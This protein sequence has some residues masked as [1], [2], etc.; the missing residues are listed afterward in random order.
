MV[1]PIEKPEEEKEEVDF[2]YE[3][4]GAAVGDLNLNDRPNS[5][6]TVAPSLD[7]VKSSKEHSNQPKESAKPPYDDSD[8][9]VKQLIDVKYSYTG[10]SKNIP[11]DKAKSLFKDENKDDLIQSVP[12]S[13]LKK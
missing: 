2:D 8:E 10:N 13:Y 11:S 4:T 3:E 12:A 7:E 9:L 1:S 6:R 5:D